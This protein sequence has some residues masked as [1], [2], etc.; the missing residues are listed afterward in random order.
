MPQLIGGLLIFLACSIAGF[1]GAAMYKQRRD[2]LEAFLKL[3]SHIKARID[4]CRAPLDTIFTEYTDRLLKGC[5]F[6]DATLTA[7]PVDAFEKCKARLCLSDT[8]ADE[9]MKF[10]SGLGSHPAAEESAHCAY[11]EKRIGELLE[12][13][14]RELPRIT[15]L[16]R[17]IGILAGV[18]AAI[19]L[20]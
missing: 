3:I 6:I 16:C 1:S 17:G 12:A 5:G 14:R 10:F 11:Y 15:K 9:L 20:I 2:E 8:Q 13:E 4:Y 7:R 19:L 18:M